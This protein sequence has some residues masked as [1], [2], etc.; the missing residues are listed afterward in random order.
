MKI[1]RLIDTGE[2]TTRR[3]LSL[4]GTLLIWGIVAIDAWYLWPTQLG[5]D[6]SIVVV[7]GKSMEPTYFGGDM[8]IARK[9]GPSVGDVII[10]APEGLGGSQIV[11]RIIGGNADEG[12]QMQGDNNDF[13]DPFTPRGAEVKGVVL[14]HYSN[15]GRVTVLLL[16]PMVW[17]FVLL[18]AMVLMLWYTGDDCDDNDDDDEEAGE[19]D[20]DPESEAEDEPDLIDRVVE[21]AEAAVSRMVSSGAAAGATALSALTS[22]ARALRPASPALLRGSAVLAVVGLLALSGMSPASASQLT[23]NVAGKVSIATDSKCATQNLA[24]TPSGTSAG[25][26]YS[27]VTVAG[28]AAACLNKPINVYLHNSAGAIVATFSSTMPASGS[29]M[30]LTLTGGATFDASLVTKAVAK[31]KGWLFVASWSYTS[32]PPSTTPIP[33]F[34]CSAVNSGGQIPNGQ[35]CTVTNG[36]VEKWNGGAG[37]AYQYKK[38]TFT[39]NS[40]MD[41]FLV[42]FNFGDSATYGPWSAGV[43]TRVWSRGQVVRATLPTA[44]AYSCTSLP[45]L[46]LNRNLSGDLSIMNFEILV[47]NDPSAAPGAGYTQVCPQ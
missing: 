26:L 36:V 28:I 13:I 39:V 23:V 17:A 12:W 18:A 47:S 34:S 35:P 3:Y 16:N 46:S 40:G 29:T 33:D 9:M 27:Q 20:G 24:V 37:N 1:R 31:V 8:V 19:D 4:L 22:R 43:P 7:S 10:Y 6:T 44:S 5:G 30:T 45:T 2:W 15:F 32:T 14:V 38:V 25:S 11:H 41:N 21:G 42:T